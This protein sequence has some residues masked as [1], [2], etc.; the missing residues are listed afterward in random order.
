MVLTVTQFPATVVAPETV[1]VPP[2]SYTL[3][4]S[5]EGYRFDP[6]SVT[7]AAGDAKE[8]RFTGDQMEAEQPPVGASSRSLLL[9]LA[10]VG[11]ILVIF[12]ALRD[13]E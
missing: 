8:I 10:V 4:A 1:L 3:T 6:V 11:I 7:V 5:R 13:D 2:G 12:F 9:P